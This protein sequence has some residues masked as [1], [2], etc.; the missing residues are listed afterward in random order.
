[1]LAG[2]FPKKRNWSFHKTL[3][4]TVRRPKLAEDK[5][6]HFRAAA[7]SAIDDRRRELQAGNAYRGMVER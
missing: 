2:F 4:W 7:V 6:E 3:L 5:A 1:M